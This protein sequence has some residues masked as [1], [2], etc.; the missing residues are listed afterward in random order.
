MRNSDLFSGVFSRRRFLV[1]L[2]GAAALAAGG[3]AL[4]AVWR[5]ARFSAPVR[6]DQ[7]RAMLGTWIRIVVEH[8]APATAEAAVGDAFAAVAAVDREMSVFRGDS[9][10]STIN[11]AA[12]RGAVVVSP[13]LREVLAIATAMAKRTHGVYSPAVL[14]LMRA[15]GF[16]ASG[17]AHWPSDRAL[18]RLEALSDWRGVRLDGHAA[19]L[20]TPGAGLDLGSIGKGW[21]VD[22][23][24]AAL[25]AR[26]VRN[27]LVDAGGNIYALGAPDD[28]ADG[29]GWQIGV[30][31]P[32][33]GEVQRTLLLRDAAV[34]TSANT[35]QFHDV[36][37]VRVGH[38]LDA[39]RGLPS[40]AHR[41]VTIHARTAVEADVAST[42]AFV[43]SLED[44]RHW[45]GVLAVYG[46]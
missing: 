11:H 23:A 13:A 26:G 1:G 8:D 15:Y 24:V 44:A 45:P 35:E 17:A 43:T 14:P 3:R 28:D 21:A 16:Y 19:G 10:V 2:G 29:R 9:A 6:V 12:G 31:D 46:G 42:A 41:S 36:D 34:A 25:R 30:L 38:L 32:A 39:V 18:A 37:G 27:G 33:S 5:G 7:T 22:R 20:A 4:P 40:R